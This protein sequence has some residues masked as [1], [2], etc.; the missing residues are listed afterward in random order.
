MKRSLNFNWKF[1][2]EYKD[3]FL[4]SLNEGE[5]VNI[6]HSVK[7]VPYNY[8]SE[9]DYQI[10]STYEKFFDVD[11]LNETRRYL[12]RFDGF[13]VKAKIYLNDELLGDFVSAYIPVEIEVTKLLKK[14]NNRLLV[15][16]DG[17][18][19]EEVP[20]FGFA[21]DYLTF[22]G[23]Y[24]EV[25][26]IDEPLTYLRNIFVQADVNGHVKVSYDVVGDGQ[27]ILEHHLYKDD[28]EILVS[29]TDEFDVKDVSLWS[30]SSPNLY[31]LKTNLVG[32]DQCYE[33]RFGFRKIE[34]RNDGFYLNGEHIKLIGLNRHQGYPYMGYAASKSLQRDDADV[35]RKEIGVNVVRTSHYPQSEHFMN[36]CDEIG[37]L[38]V[39]EIP[40][41]QHL[42]KSE[43]WRNNCL[44][45]TEVMVKTQ[46]NH[47]SL[48]LHG[49]RVD[50][51]VDD[52]E[53]YTKTNEIAHKFD[54]TRPTIGVR[55][56]T[57]S[58]CLEYVYGYNDFTCWNLKKGLLE[59]KKVKTQGHPL[60][61]TEYM[62]H[63]DPAK[64]TSDTPKKL[65]V[66]LKHAKVI[67]DNFKYD[68]VCGAIGWC[69][70]D[71]HT[72]V[73]FGSGDHLCTHG[74]MDLYRNPKFSASI[75][76]SQQEEFPVLEIL[77]NMKPGD[78]PAA[79][80]DY[81]YVSTNCDYIKLYKNDQYVGTF[82]P[83][84]VEPFPYLKHPPILVDDIVGE[85]F[86]EERFPRKIHAKIAEALSYAA[87]HGFGNIL[88]RHK[89]F[90]ASCMV[91][92]KMTYTDLVG[93]WNKYVGSWGGKAMTFRFEG[94]KNDT[95][96]MEKELGPSLKFDLDVSIKNPHL[97]NE[98]TYDT[99]QIKLKHLDEHGMIANY[100]NRIIRIKTE[101]PI[102]LIG[103]NEQTLLG[104][105][106]TIY[107]KSTQENGPAKVTL[108]MDDITRVIDLDVKS[109]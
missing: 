10:L 81:I 34:F 79:I 94:Y 69:F 63:M 107:I 54:P 60:L 90:L 106:L 52:H 101:G 85:T 86:N 57:G 46:R 37:L 19:N 23:I 109:R 104:G 91:K 96:V 14:K 53:L 82:Y 68:E 3:E 65:E 41:W 15:I 2:P 72:H 1:V 56:F 89:V 47:P 74:V 71:Y 98:D 103:P 4:K 78:F 30:I 5:M 43:T 48:I 38:V 77:T 35:L 80:F 59:P 75:Y 18:E 102:E 9:F 95:K 108:K 6:P 97:V 11:D 76:A 87:I 42:G 40:G 105:Q 83:H 20:P 36:R 29:K 22:S 70:V 12:L 44:K 16:L 27:I 26:L 64:P 17:K 21:V 51:S 49:V 25:Y 100:S 93:Y 88:P 73:D 92:Y 84:F 62:G 99:A 58:E 67:N 33:T 55:N 50:E 24:R 39:N 28:K 32:L 8:F 31:V 7:E 45:N 61:V 66:A 13:M